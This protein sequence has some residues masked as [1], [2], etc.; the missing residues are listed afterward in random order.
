[1]SLVQFIKEKEVNSIIGI[2]AT[3]EQDKPDTYKVSWVE[4]TSLDLTKPIVLTSTIAATVGRK[5]AKKVTVASEL[6]DHFSYFSKVFGVSPSQFL[7]S[8]D[9]M[10][11]LSKGKSFGISPKISE[12]QAL[13][14]LQNYCR[15][16]L[17]KE[18]FSVENKTFYQVINF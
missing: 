11:F 1:M 6:E 12:E 15:L 9:Q 8:D 10:F 14:F 16:L 13:V 2:L 17:F 7:S 5:K 4:K 3:Q 18:G